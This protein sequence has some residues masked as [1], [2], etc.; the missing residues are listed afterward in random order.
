MQISRFDRQTDSATSFPGDFCY[1]LVITND[2]THFFFA[3]FTA[4]QN[5]KYFSVFS[6]MGDEKIFVKKKICLLVQL[7]IDAVYLQ[8][9]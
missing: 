5:E 6:D 3:N 2:C 1:C 8:S 7:S 4:T 9:K